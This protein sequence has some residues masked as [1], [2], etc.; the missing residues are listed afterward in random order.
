MPLGPVA[1]RHRLR[2][3]ASAPTQQAKIAVE[4][5]LDVEDL[6]GDRVVES[7]DD[8]KRLGP[9]G[10][11]AHAARESDAP[12]CSADPDA[13]SVAQLDSGRA[14]DR[15]CREWRADRVAEGA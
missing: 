6:E 3:S 14:M 11:D 10:D 8:D 12:I 4:L 5:V 13:D 9:P 1:A 2:S 15:L 7:G